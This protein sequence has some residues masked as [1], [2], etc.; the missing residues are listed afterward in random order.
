MWAIGSV[1]GSLS[2]N[3]AG[4]NVVTAKGG[5]AEASDCGVVASCWDATDGLGSSEAEGVAVGLVAA[6]V[7]GICCCEKPKPN[8][9]SGIASTPN[10]IGTPQLLEAGGWGG[11]TGLRVKYCPSRAQ[12]L[13]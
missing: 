13:S 6:V 2:G 11:G 4:T 9:S 1:A 8:M 3:A 12:V 7:A 10:A 5:V